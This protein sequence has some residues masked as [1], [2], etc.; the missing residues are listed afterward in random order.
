MNGAMNKKG[1][2]DS[3]DTWDPAMPQKAQEHQPLRME[4]IY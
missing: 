4:S 1:K 3:I 2:K